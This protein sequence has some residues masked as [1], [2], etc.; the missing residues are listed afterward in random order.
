MLLNFSNHQHNSWPNEQQDLANREFSSVTDMLF[1]DID[2]ML[3]SDGIK[4]LAL[5]Y[6]EK[7]SQIMQQAKNTSPS[8]KHAVHIM[9]EFTF[10]FTLINLLKE[11][12]ILCVASTT[13][14]IV[15]MKEGKKISK[16][17]FCSFRDY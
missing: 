15:E 16:F 12:G 14:R 17:E 1:P 2:T 6:S 10:C 4:E 5:V 8:E 3:S 7:I 9:G 13:K 11:K